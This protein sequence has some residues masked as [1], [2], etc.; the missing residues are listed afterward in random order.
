MG[1]ISPGEEYVIFIRLLY[2]IFNTCVTLIL[3]SDRIGKLLWF[4]NALMLVTF[5]RKHMVGQ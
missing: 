2:L 3:L 4:Q 5:H 1:V